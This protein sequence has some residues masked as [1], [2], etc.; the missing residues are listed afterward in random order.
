MH[1]LSITQAVTV[2]ASFE[3]MFI[4]TPYFPGVVTPN[5]KIDRPKIT[6]PPYLSQFEIILT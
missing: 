3:M 4:C 2:I 5:F 6:P 1:A